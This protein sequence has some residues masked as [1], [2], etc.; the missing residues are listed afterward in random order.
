MVHHVMLFSV[1]ESVCVHE[2][3]SWMCFCSD[4]SLCVFSHVFSG[5][6]ELH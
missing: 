5:R 3:E 2:H 4:D 1:F 6:C